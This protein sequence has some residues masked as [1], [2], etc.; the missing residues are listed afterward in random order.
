MLR[1]ALCCSAI[2]ALQDPVPPA[3]PEVPTPKAEADAAEAQALSRYNDQRAKA[4]DTPAAQ[5]KLALWCEQNGLKPESY[6]HFARVIELD[7]KRDAAWQKLGYKRHDGHW[8]TNEQIAA[9]AGRKAAEKT[10][11]A[12]LKKWHKEFHPGKKPDERKADDARAALE[13]ISDPAAIS[14]I[15]REFAGGGGADQAIALQLLGQIASPVASKGIAM[16]AVYGKSPDVRRNATEILRGRPAEDYLDLL[17]GLMK[18]PLRYEVRPVGGPG[19]PG[20]LLVEGEKFNVQRFYAPPAPTFNFRPGDMIGYDASGM[21][22]VMRSTTSTITGTKVGVPGSKSLVTEKD[23]VSTR[24]DVYSF[25][26]AR[27]EAQRAAFAAQAQLEGDI[28]QIGAINDQRKRFTDLVIAVARA[29]TGKSPDETAKGW[30]AEL[31][32]G[33]GGRYARRTRERPKPTFGESVPL[34]YIPAFA[35]N[36][37]TQMQTRVVT[38]TFVDS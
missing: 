33:K 35:A 6:V 28:K 30:R 15:L 7:P 10:W 20:I 3:S 18:D 24:T 5:W 26:N 27:L 16:L 38:Q 8:M 12:Q 9:E 36:V 37:S 14:P 17:V 2:L 29:A 11:T 13:K 32:I 31:E 22:I 1:L 21:P 25:E 23:T 34:D 4:P 19:S